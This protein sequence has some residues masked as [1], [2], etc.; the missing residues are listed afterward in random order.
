MVRVVTVKAHLVIGGGVK[1]EQLALVGRRFTVA[2]QA[3]D[4]CT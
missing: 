1:A 3:A 4:R 2:T